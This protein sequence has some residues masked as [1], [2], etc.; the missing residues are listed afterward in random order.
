MAAT[1]WIIEVLNWAPDGWERAPHAPQF[2]ARDGAEA[3]VKA[4]EARDNRTYR[5]VQV[6]LER[7]G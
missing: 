2:T 6:T 7:P 1:R 5:A 3:Y 4:A